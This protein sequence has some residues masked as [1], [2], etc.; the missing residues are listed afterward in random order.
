MPEAHDERAANDH[1]RTTLSDVCVKMS[2]EVRSWDPQMRGRAVAMVA[3]YS[4]FDDDSDD[5]HDWGAF[6]FAGYLLEWWIEPAAPDA[7]SKARILT[8]HA[9]ADVLCE[10]IPEDPAQMEVAMDPCRKPP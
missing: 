10:R 8:L 3:R 9:T 6:I 1:A 5:A 4:A 7:M 2:H